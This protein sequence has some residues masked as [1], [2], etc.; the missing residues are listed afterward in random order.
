MQAALC[1][2][3]YCR[4]YPPNILGVIFKVENFRNMVQ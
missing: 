2:Q 4:Q 3:A 1:V